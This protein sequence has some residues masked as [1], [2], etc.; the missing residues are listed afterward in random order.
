LRLVI[1]RKV[2]EVAEQLGSHWADFYEF[3]IWSF[4]ENSSRKF[5]FD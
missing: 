1:V 5:K 4:F 3:D 2:G